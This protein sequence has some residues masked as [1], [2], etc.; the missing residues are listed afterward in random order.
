MIAAAEQLKCV[1]R[2]VIGDLVMKVFFWRS[3]LLPLLPYYVKQGVSGQGQDSHR[4]VWKKCFI[5]GSLGESLLLRKKVCFWP[6]MRLPRECQLGKQLLESFGESLLWKK[7]FA[8]I[9]WKLFPAPILCK[10]RYVQAP[11]EV[12][13]WK[14]EEVFLSVGKFLRINSNF[15]LCSSQS[16]LTLLLAKINISTTITILTITITTILTITIT[17]ILY[18][19]SDLLQCSSGVGALSGGG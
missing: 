2:A 3:A 10:T 5:L 6:W 12:S 9:M 17:I 8:P 18:A 15:F 1:V 11:T 13:A 7:C 19:M 4:S 16:T 14:A